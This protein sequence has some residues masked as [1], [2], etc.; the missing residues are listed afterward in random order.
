MNY[1][2]CTCIHVYPVICTC[3]YK[4]CTRYGR[5]GKQCTLSDAYYFMMQYWIDILFFYRAFCDTASNQTVTITLSFS[6]PYRANSFTFTYMPPIN[7]TSF[8]AGGNELKAFSGSAEYYVFMSVVT[9]LYGILAVVVYII[10]Y[11]PRYDI[12]KY[13]SVVVSY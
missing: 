2:Y 12:A 3:T 5:L 9:F 4:Q 1:M 10:F 6:Y 13:L 11:V 7:D 8:C